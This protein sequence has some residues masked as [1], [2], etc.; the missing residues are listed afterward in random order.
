MNGRSRSLN[1]LIATGSGVHPEIMWNFFL[2]FNFFLKLLKKNSTHECST[3][4]RDSNRY[5]MN[6]IR[7]SIPFSSSFALHGPTE[8]NIPNRFLAQHRDCYHP[9]NPNR[10]LLSLVFL[11]MAFL[12]G[13]MFLVL[14]LLFNLPTLV[15]PAECNQQLGEE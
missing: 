7:R 10:Y 8:P 12:S 11:M 2:N 1:S 13:S 3:R 6:S 14:L 4:S 5:R 15:P 9:V